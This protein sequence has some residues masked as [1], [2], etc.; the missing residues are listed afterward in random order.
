MPYSVY[1]L[2]HF[3]GMFTMVTALA[4][5]S[6]HAIRGGTR[7]DNPHRRTL[8]AAHGIATFLVLLGGFGMLARLELIRG[9]LP[10]WVIV[11]LVIWVALAAALAVPNYGRGYA[12]ALLVALPLLAV[13][14]AA[15]ALYKPF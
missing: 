7:A 8:A 12:R 3:L 15:V 9:G 1:K 2:I 4:A 5:I 13:S 10:A 11:K 6:M 14:A